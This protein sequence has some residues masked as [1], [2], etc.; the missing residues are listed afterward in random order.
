MVIALIGRIHEDRG[1][2]S[3]INLINKLNH[4][5]QDFDVIIIG[6]GQTESEFL[7]KIKNIIPR[8][9]LKVLG[10]LSED[11]LAKM[12]PKIGVLVSLAPVESYGRVIREAYISGVPV[13]VS[14]SSGALDL[15][16]TAN[17]KGIKLIDINHSDKAL[18]KEFESLLV[19]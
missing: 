7:T 9:R 16:S 12:W 8:Q 18:L 13:W 19:L 11:L 15:I 6:S 3:F 10:Q 2:W 1:I 4:V 5:S 17:S 14:K